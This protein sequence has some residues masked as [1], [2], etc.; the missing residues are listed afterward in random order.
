MLNVYHVDN[1]EI[2]GLLYA[3][4]YGSKG[5]YRTSL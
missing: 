3:I 2:I 4:I 5:K 1:Q